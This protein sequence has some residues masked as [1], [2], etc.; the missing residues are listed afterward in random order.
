MQ[1]NGSKVGYLALG[2]FDYLFVIIIA[3]VALIVIALIVICLYVIY[4]FLVRPII[5][6][7]ALQQN[8]GGLEGQ[9]A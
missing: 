3:L 4:R 7:N 1:V 5:R 2:G 9:L 6:R 8:K